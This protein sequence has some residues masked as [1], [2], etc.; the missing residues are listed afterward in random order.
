MVNNTEQLQM[1]I[2]QHLIERVAY[3][4]DVVRKKLPKIEFATPSVHFDCKGR[5]SGNAT[6]ATHTVGFNTVLAEENREAFDNTVIHELAHL[7]THKLFP[8]AKQSHGP[9]FKRVFRFLGGNGKRGHNYDVTNVAKVIGRKQTR[10][11]YVCGCTIS[12][13]LSA[14]R[15]NRIQAG[16]QTYSCNRCRQKIQFAKQVA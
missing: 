12:H 6:Y 4:S 15:H 16:K 7:V 1:D 11:Y 2:K 13:E 14:T 8:Y 9:E 3:Y 5:T 10:Y